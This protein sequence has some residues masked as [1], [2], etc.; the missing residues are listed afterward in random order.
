MASSVRNGAQRMASVSS[1]LSCRRRVFR[2]SAWCATR[3]ISR[4]LQQYARALQ[5]VD[6][7]NHVY[8]VF[9]VSAVDAIAPDLERE[10]GLGLLVLAL[11]D[12]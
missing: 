2:L 4:H 9:H 1:S 6:V 11:C 8:V 3:K 7:E 5:D 10:K 12:E